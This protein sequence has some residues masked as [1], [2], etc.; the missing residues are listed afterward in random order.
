VELIEMRGNVDT[1]L[2]RV[3]GTAAD[4][5]GVGGDLDAVVL[6]VA[7]LSRLG[8]AARIA[9]HLDPELVMPAPGQ[10]ALAV[11]VSADL[12]ATGT[13]DATAL[14]DALRSLDDPWTRAAVTAERTLLAA[15]E[16]GCS[17]PV[18]ALAL[19]D[20]DGPE[21][22]VHLRAVLARTDGSL[23]RKSTTGPAGDAAEMGR[24]LAADLLAESDPV[25]M[26][27]TS[28][29]TPHPTHDQG[30]PTR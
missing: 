25:T 9:E 26:A 20:R 17:A 27:G 15:L 6:A 28:A 5:T 7:G 2:A 3:H 21:H 16:A 23:V 19:V 13:A 30:S 22:T 14:T 29:A 10:G 18:G 1:R 4:D 11:E 8:R 12:A 24:R